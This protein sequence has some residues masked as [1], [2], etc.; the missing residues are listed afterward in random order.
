MATPLERVAVGEGMV[1]LSSEKVTCPGMGPDAAELTVAVRAELCPRVTV[2]G[3][4]ATVMM[5]DAAVTVMVAAL[6]AVV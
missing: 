2:V 1:P 4:A 3:L 6:V 5:V